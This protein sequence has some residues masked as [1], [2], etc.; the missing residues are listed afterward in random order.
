[1]SPE[2][3][4]FSP[5]EKVIFLADRSKVGEVVTEPDRR[6]G[7]YWYRIVLPKGRIKTVAGDALEG[8][9]AGLQP[10][11][12]FKRRSFGDL[13]DF[14]RV[15]TFQKLDAPLDNTLYALRASRTEFYPH[16]YKPLIKFLKSRDQR[17]L[18]ADEVGL[19]KTIE[20]G[21]ILV[22]QRARDAVRQALVVCPASLC[23]KWQEEMRRR[24]DEEFE[25]LDGH[26]FRRMIR[27][28]ED[29]GRLGEFKAIYS[30][31]SLRRQENIDML[32]ATP[33]P[34]DLLIVDEAH[35]LR[36]PSSNSHQVV[37]A[38]A[39]RAAAILFLTATPIHLGNENLF[40]LFH[41]LE[42]GE[43]RDFETFR[44]L[45]RAN[46]PVVEAKRLS[47]QAR[48]FPAE[49]IRERLEKM[50]SRGYEEYFEDNPIYDRVRSKLATTDE[51]DQA[52]V[53]RLQRDLEDLN[54]IGHIFTRTKKK[55]VFEEPNVRTA[56][57]KRPS[58]TEE[59][60]EFY[61]AV[62]ELI[63]EEAAE[64]SGTIQYFSIMSAQRQMASSMH[65]VK[66]KYTQKAVR[67]A[68]TDPENTDLENFESESDDQEDTILAP[69][70]R[71]IKAARSLGEKDT[72]YQALLDVIEE[73][74]E[75]KSD[76]R[77]MVFS[78]Y[79]KTL[80]YLKRRLEEDG[81]Q[82]L[83]VHGDVE[84]HPDD[85]ERD[86]RGRRVRQFEADEGP[87]ILLSSEVSSEG[88]DFQFCHTLINYDLPW[89][90]MR[91]EQRIGRLDRLGQESDRIIIV[92]F[93]IPGTIEEKILDRLYSRINIFEK[94]IGDL[95]SILGDEIQKLSRELL[96]TQLTPEEE[97]RRIEQAARAIERQKRELE[98]LE[99]EAEGFVGHEEYLETEL[100]RIQQGGE[101]L[102]AGDCEKFFRGFL[103][104]FS[105]EAS[106]EDT[107]RSD[108]YR[109][110]VDHELETALKRQPDSLARRRF[111]ASLGRGE[112][113]VTF[114][115]STAHEADEV[116]FLRAHHPLMKVA[117]DYYRENPGGLH[118]V[119]S[120]ELEE[121][122]AV[123]SGRYFY[124]LRRVTIEGGRERQR[125]EALF[126]E[127]D[128]DGQP[129]ELVDSEK[130]SLLLG[131]MLRNG[132]DADQTSEIEE[133]D[134]AEVM[135]EARD[136]FLDRISRQQQQ[137]EERNE[138]RIQQQLVSLR[139]THETRLEKKRELLERARSKNYE[140]QYVRMLEGT[141]RNMKSDYKKRR[142]ELEGE[143][144][145]HVSSEFVGC[146]LLRVES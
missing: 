81:F 84:S 47:H 62:T 144:D 122:D 39:D 44:D 66:D 101:F 105:D 69:S 71:V 115:A 80:S 11:D 49:A 13:S 133:V 108:V 58:M 106:L 118:A 12:L 4:K 74:Q 24:F 28:L 26:D 6:Q 95:E 23:G 90:P 125:L 137:I 120:I 63:R 15:V 77:I 132:R 7:K 2:E 57:V 110:H 73:L 119:S 142:N 107:R 61:S 45:L 48:S 88:L 38:L 92:N 59:E 9:Q 43:F 16:Q 136:L 102:T 130:S 55:E 52:D 36:N 123:D 50:G 37:R 46:K 5:G 113:E 117:V 143:R 126:L 40:Q 131:E 104:A 100:R 97:E 27:D 64:R 76:R 89:N 103:E 75:A 70:Q 21:H 79:R 141:I 96:S 60:A 114:D 72:K 17:L 18:I 146:G 116:E 85:P 41:L 54:L 35:H 94:S 78:F 25:V 19:G 99:K 51:W 3:P 109:L 129:G 34:L 98:R 68:P 65:A 87:S 135:N 1:M 31:Q 124:G 33:L 134:A 82:C 140:E 56:K 8:F 22:E 111:L 139:K 53:A 30:L 121:S 14:V 67:V 20:A 128:E 91:V 145:I 138:A 10:E 42:P 29:R 93:S 83:V 86:E 112:V 127:I 32:E